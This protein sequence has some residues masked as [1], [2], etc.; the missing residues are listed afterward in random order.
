MK[1]NNKSEISK[2]DLQKLNSLTNILENL[3]KA[4]GKLN[5]FVENVTSDAEL[6]NLFLMEKITH[7]IKETNEKDKR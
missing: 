3:E 7:N 2:E 1:M 5:T 4:I 6:N